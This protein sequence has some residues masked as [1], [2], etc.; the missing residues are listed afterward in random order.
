MKCTCLAISKW[1]FTQPAPPLVLLSSRNF[2]TPQ[3]YAFWFTLLFE[4]VWSKGKT[5]LRQ[6]SGLAVFSSVVGACLVGREVGVPPHS[7]GAWGGACQDGELEGLAVAKG[8]V[9]LPVC[10]GTEPGASASRD[11]NTTLGSRLH[12]LR[13]Q[14]ALGFLAGPVCRGP[15]GLQ[16]VGLLC[17]DGERPGQSRLGGFPCCYLA[18]RCLA[19]DVLDCIGA[20]GL[21]SRVLPA[22]V[23]GGPFWNCQTVLGPYVWLSPHLLHLG[24]FH[25]DWTDKA[26]PEV[27]VNL[28]TL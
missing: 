23:D 6:R 13:A 4:E 21:Q 27:L 18:G 8:Q 9:G 11:R 22:G 7:W 26:G 3:L 15:E 5:D 19:H 20:L 28:H 2:P 16:N 14:L 12:P 25:L 17:S 10:R 24:P 1:T